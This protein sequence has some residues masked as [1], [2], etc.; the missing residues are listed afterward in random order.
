MSLADHGAI[1]DGDVPEISRRLG[2]QLDRV[3][4]RREMA[5]RHAHV[6]GRA[7]NT[8]RE[9]RL[10]AQR[11][12]ARF[13]VTPRDAD[14]LTAVGIDAIRVAVQDRHILD[15]DAPAAEQRYGVV[16]GVGDGEIADVDLL[17]APQGDRLRAVALPPITVDPSGPDEPDLLHVTALDEGEAVIR[18]LV[19]RVRLVA[20]L[21]RRVEVPVIRARDQDRPGIELKG[22]Q[23]SKVQRAREIVSRRESD[24]LA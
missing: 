3:V 5:S 20:E 22:R 19:V 1:A 4:K 23:I 11:I 15:V 9:A 21:L 10:Q 13:D 17:A 18:R 14:V 24:G 2:S 8:E 16:A 6:L 7:A 12:V